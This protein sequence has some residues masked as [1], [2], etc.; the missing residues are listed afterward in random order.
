MTLNLTT[1]GIVSQLQANVGCLQRHLK[2]IQRQ[3]EILDWESPD[4]PESLSDSE[5][6]QLVQFN[7]RL[8]ALEQYLVAFTTH[9]EPGLVSSMADITSPIDDY[10]ID[11]TLYFMLAEHDPE[12]DEND[13]NFITTRDVHLKGLGLRE[14]HRG[15]ADGLDHKE[16]C[17]AHLFPGALKTI[18]HCRLFYELYSCNFGL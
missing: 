6:A 15:F 8:M 16:S 2:R 17:C 14:N 4:T 13:D 10:E 5:I 12:Y 9:H 3:F 7:K 1:R 18:P 11:A